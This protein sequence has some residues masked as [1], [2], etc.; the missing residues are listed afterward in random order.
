MKPTTQVTA[1]Q[2]RQKQLLS[3]LTLWLVTELLLTLVGLDTLADY[4][5]FLTSQTATHLSH[6]PQELVLSIAVSQ[7]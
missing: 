2:V 1:M 7:L 3:D 6:N 4:G 5:E